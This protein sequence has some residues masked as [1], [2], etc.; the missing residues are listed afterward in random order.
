MAAHKKNST[1]HD[2]HILEHRW[3]TPETSYTSTSFYVVTHYKSKSSYTILV[4]WKGGNLGL[5]FREN[6][7][8][9]Y[10]WQNLQ[11]F[12]GSNIYYH[13]VMIK[14]PISCYIFYALTRP[15]H[16]VRK[17]YRNFEKLCPNHVL[18]S[19]F[20]PHWLVRH[21]LWTINPLCKFEENFWNHQK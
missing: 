2:S 15:L 13:E 18:I 14:M 6:L 11:D 7:W 12:L 5:F 21:Y 19:H 17:S 10:K 1:N 4:M 16:Y 20:R 9:G 8:L 3:P